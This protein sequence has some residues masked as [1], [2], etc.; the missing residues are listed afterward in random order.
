MNLLN[1]SAPQPY[2]GRDAFDSRYPGYAIFPDGSWIT[3]GIAYSAE[4][5]IVMNTTG[6]EVTE[7]FQQDMDE[8]TMEFINISNLLLDTDFYRT[9]RGKG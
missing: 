8:R 9:K 3:E 5:G 7:T 1:V 4:R 2:L 6:R